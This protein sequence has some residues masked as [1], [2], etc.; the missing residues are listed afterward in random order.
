[1]MQLTQRLILGLV[2]AGLSLGAMAQDIWTGGV[3]IEERELAPQR[4][5]RIQFFVEGGPYLADVHYVL[6]DER[7]NRL[8]EGTA[9][10]PWLLLNLDAGTYSVQATRSETGETQSARFFKEGGNRLVLGLEFGRVSAD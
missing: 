8:H 3:G 7:G 6:Y 1:M 10:G 9:D 4:N 5:T 2:V